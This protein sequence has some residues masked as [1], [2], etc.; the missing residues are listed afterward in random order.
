MVIGLF[1]GGIVPMTIAAL[2]M[3]AVGRAAFGMVQ[4]VRRQFREILGLMEGTVKADTAR[5]VEI[6]TGAALKEMIVPG[7]S[8]VVL[9]TLYALTLRLHWRQLS[10]L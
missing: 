9:L 8:A 10:W 3:R 6:A 7:L 1:L 4:E 5:C 2:T